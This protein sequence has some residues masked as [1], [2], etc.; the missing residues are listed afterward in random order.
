MS[1]QPVIPMSG[2]GGWKFL[3]STY[4]RQLANHSDSPQVRRDRDYLTEKLANPIAVEDFIADKR[5]L[6]TAL[7][8]FGL[9]GEEWKGGFINKVLKE[10]SDPESSFLPRLNNPR[11]TAFANALAPS[12]GTIEVDA[13]GLARMAVRFETNAFNAAVG[14]I[15][16]TMRLALN[17]K[18]EIG[19][20]VGNGSS[21]EAI[22]YRLLGDLPVSN[23]LKTALNLPDSSVK[24]P[25]ERQADMLKA[26]LQKVLGVRNMAEIAEPGNV[27]KLIE[28]FHIMSSVNAGPSMSTPGV[29]ALSLLSG[30]SFG[31]G[32]N[33]SQNLFLSLLR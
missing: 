25:I 22:L 4:D 2:L 14:D 28:R 15:D 16:D 17:Y 21:D 24:L 11:Y 10:A 18:S 13:D 8:A 20:L 3:Q 6:R 33:E 31:L 26:G 27:E 9:G 5:L 7:T 29:A 19:E 1:F 12:N 32:A 30:G 23:V